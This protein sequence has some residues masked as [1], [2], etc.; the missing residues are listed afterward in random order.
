MEEEATGEQ[1]ILGYKV[2]EIVDYDVLPSHANP[3]IPVKRN[4]VRTPP[5]PAFF[6]FW[7]YFVCPRTHQAT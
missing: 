7:A 4:E 6:D 5:V 3:Q 2:N 1:P